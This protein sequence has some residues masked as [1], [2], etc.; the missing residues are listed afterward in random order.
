MQIQNDVLQLFCV[1]DSEQNLKFFFIE[2]LLMVVA[3]KKRQLQSMNHLSTSQ[4]FLYFINLQKDPGVFSNLK[5]LLIG[6]NKL[7]G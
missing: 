4:V 3:K 7:K 1:L 6:Q 2:K 5:K